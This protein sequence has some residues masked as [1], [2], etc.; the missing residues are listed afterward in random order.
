MCSYYGVGVV[1]TLVLVE[2]RPLVSIGS[3]YVSVVS[4]KSRGH[5]GWVSISSENMKPDD[6]CI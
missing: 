4:A 2:L 1:A 6:A 3:L 5:D